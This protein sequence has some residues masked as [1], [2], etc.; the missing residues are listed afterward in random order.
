MRLA[1]PVIKTTLLLINVFTHLLK[2]SILHLKQSKGWEQME[3]STVLKQMPLFPILS[4]IFP[5]AVNDVADVLIEA[6]F[7]CATVPLSTPEPY[8]SIQQLCLAYN[9]KILVGA[10]EV[11]GATDVEKVANQGA[12][13]IIS[14]H[15]DPEIIKHCSQRQM[16][17]ISLCTTSEEANQASNLGA[18]AIL[19]PLNEKPL[20][21]FENFRANFQGN[22]PIIL[23]AKLYFDHMKKNWEAGAN[24][25]TIESELYIPDIETKTLAHH[26]KEFSKKMRDILNK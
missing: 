11:E 7:L 26:A 17:C 2:L 1:A 12:T 18:N 8:A 25:F 5:H 4:G 16:I 22:I 6:G 20:S 15:Y 24:G 23:S 19:Y 3:F 21:E 13:L 10:A 14:A 9:G